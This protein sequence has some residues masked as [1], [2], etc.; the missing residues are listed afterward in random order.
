MCAMTFDDSA[1]DLCLKNIDE[2]ITDDLAILF[3]TR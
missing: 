1:R 2:Q 3:R